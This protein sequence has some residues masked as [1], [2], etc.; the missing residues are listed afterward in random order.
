MKTD[1]GRA[2]RILVVDDHPR[3]L[4]ALLRFLA[5][6]LPGLSLAGAE[7]AERALELCALEA[8]DL[9]IMDI[10]LPGMNGIEAT[11][12][13]RTLFPDTCVVMH[14]AYEIGVYGDASITAG[15]S[16]YV[17]KERSTDE[18]VPVIVALLAPSRSLQQA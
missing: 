13:V 2:A 5:A 16:A 4:A 1:A 12:R 18:L 14:S 3:T 9:V 11:R 6:S 17:A 10:G 8:P 15:A 7:S